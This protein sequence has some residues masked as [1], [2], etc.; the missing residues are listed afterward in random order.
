M[1]RLLRH[2]LR[3]LQTVAGGSDLLE[4]E[5]RQSIAEEKPAGDLIVHNQD[6]DFFSYGH[7]VAPFF[8]GGC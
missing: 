2:D 3:T 6:F 1:V 7:L 8:S 5:L 4:T